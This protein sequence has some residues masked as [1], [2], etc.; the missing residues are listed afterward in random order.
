MWTPKVPP[1][2][3]RQEV[4]DHD[5]HLLGI[6]DL[7]W[8]RTRILGEADGAGPHATPE[9]VFVDRHRQNNIVNAGWHLLR[10]TWQDTLRP[11]V[12]P[13][14]VRAAI[15]TRSTFFVDH[16]LSSG[17]ADILLR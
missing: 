8:L 9:A 5:G 11:D 4:R 15:A 14:K 13:E 17:K 2:T 1:D 7:A 10:F 6:G 16:E 12:I 3:L